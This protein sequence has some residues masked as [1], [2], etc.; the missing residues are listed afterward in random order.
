MLTSANVILIQV[1]DHQ[2][3]NN[4]IKLQQKF[5]ITLK[6][7]YYSFIMVIEVY[8][9]NVQIYFFFFGIN[10]LITIKNP[11]MRQLLLRIT[12]WEVKGA[13]NG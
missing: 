1:F 11:Y 2:A 13:R 8:T 7:A 3:L 10:I 5:N 12:V 4:G 9:I 6:V